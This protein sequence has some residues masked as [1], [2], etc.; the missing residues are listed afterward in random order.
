MII[1]KF[2]LSYTY[3][4]KTLSK[5]VKTKA[6]N[7]WKLNFDIPNDVLYNLY[8]KCNFFT[9]NERLHFCS[10]VQMFK[11][12]KF[13]SNCTHFDNLCT[14]TF[15]K[16]PRFQNLIN[17]TQRSSETLKRGIVYRFVNL[18][19]E[20]PNSMRDLNVGTV[21]FKKQISIFLLVQR[22]DH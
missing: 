16:S 18:W 6:K 15:S 2:V 12:L 20:L 1:S 14:F 5:I 21:N 3:K 8:E 9:V 19:N 7:F 11:L 22:N 4:T 10:L 13:G 17:I